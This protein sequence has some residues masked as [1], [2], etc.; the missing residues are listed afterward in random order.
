MSRLFVAVAAA[1][2]LSSPLAAQRG[3]A[4]GAPNGVPANDRFERTRQAVARAQAAGMTV[5]RG[6]D[7]ETVRVMRGRLRMPGDDVRGRSRAFVDTFGDAFGATREVELDD[8]RPLGRRADGT[9]RHARMTQR[10]HGFAFESHGLTLRYDEAGDIVSARGV[11]SE[12]AA[13]LPAPALDESAGRVAALA[14]LGALGM[15]EF[16]T[17]P[18]L[19]RVGRLVD[20]EPR[21]LYRIDALP[22]DRMVPVSVEIDAADGAVVRVFE[23]VTHGTGTFLY[24]ED[25]AGPLPLEHSF[26]TSS[27]KGSAYKKVSAAMAE[28]DGLTSLKD[29]GKS[30]IIPGVAMD[31]MLNGRWAQV[32]DTPDGGPTPVAFAPDYVFEYSDDDPTFTGLIEVY[33]LF[34]H[35][36]TFFWVQAAGRYMGKVYGES[37]LDYS[38]PVFVNYDDAGDGYVNAFFTTVDSDDEDSGFPPGYLL[39]GEFTGITGDVMDDLSRDPSVVIHEYTHALIHGAGGVFG[40][41]VLDSPERA[42]N[43][44]LAD[45]GASTLLKDPLVGEVFAFHSGP[46]IAFF[47]EALRDL[48]ASVTLQ[49]NLFDTPGELVGWPEEHDAGEIFGAFL[50]RSRKALKNKTTDKLFLVDMLDWP[51][52]SA[53]VGFPSLNAGNIE[54]AYDAFFSGCAD[55]ALSGVLA[56][57]GNLKKNQ[58]NAGKLLGAAMAHGLQ[59]QPD[60]G[61]YRFKVLEGE[62]L[63]LAFN[64]EFLGSLDEHQIEFDL[65]A[66]QQLTVV[67]KGDK[68]D[69]TQVDFSFDDDPDDFVYGKDKKV[70]P[71]GTL[72][73]QNKIEV[74]VAG[75]Y[76]LSLANVDSLGGRYKLVFK[77]K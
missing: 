38:L 9:T 3:Q 35:T 56:K 65:A 22:A 27:G 24:D 36:N 19:R 10:V 45:Y 61:N 37:P 48:E 54:A 40:A 59:G 13:R 2:L 76:T 50:W 14:R 28:Q 44:A 75:V 74:A 63:A 15:T 70:N 33:N 42:V 32:V 1:V 5:Q 67:I 6:D 49:D 34:D 29:L 4:G 43:E 68:K 41:G 8:A 77:V 11:V 52:S 69:A 62:K 73:S 20:G 51:Q 18:V 7:E 46:D 17:D 16:R 30:D 58:K 25:G 53:E 47:D 71:K 55:S 26:K 72:A 64:S 39:F 21:L 57:P 66:G 12:E 31:G 23:N 60:T